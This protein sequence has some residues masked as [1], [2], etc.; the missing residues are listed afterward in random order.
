MNANDVENDHFLEEALKS[1]KKHAW[2]MKRA[3]DLDN[4]KDV[5]QHA[6]DMLYELRTSRLTPR[7]YYRLYM[8]IA[9]ELMVLEHFF[10]DM[11][12]KGTPMEDLYRMVQH[13]GNVLPRLYLLVTAGSVYI[14]SKEAP[15]KDILKDVVEMAKGVQ[16][17]MRGLF[18]RNYISH[19]TKNKLPDV[20]NEYEGDGGSVQHSVDFV[21]QNF[22]EMNKLWVRM[23]YQRTHAKSK[24]EK[25]RREL[26]VLVGTNLRRLSDLEGINVEYYK[27]GVLPRILEQVISCKDAIAQ[28]YL[29]EIII[30]VFPSEFHLATLEQFLSACKA[31]KDSVNVKGIVCNLMD[32][33]S[34]YQSSDGS[35]GL[36]EIT[37]GEEDVFSI[38]NEHVKGVIA[39]K[40]NMSTGDILSLH[41][42]LI[43]FAMQCAR[44]PED[45]V[46]YANEVM[47]FCADFLEKSVGGPVDD[48]SAELLVQL[49]EAVISALVMRVLQPETERFEDLLQFLKWPQRKTIAVRLVRGIVDAPVP[50]EISDPKLVDRLLKFIAP[51]VKDAEDAPATEL[52]HAKEE[53]EEEQRLVAQ[54]IH[55]FR[56]DN[57]DV[58]YKIYEVARKRFGHGGTSRIQYT[59]VPLTFSVMRLTR[60]IH[61]LKDSDQKP[62]TNI[63]KLFRFL[64]EVVSALG[65]HYSEMAFK[66]FLSCARL[67]DSLGF[68]PIAYEYLSQSF[69]L[70]EDM[71]TAKV[72]VRSVTLAA[73]VLY[74]CTGFGEENCQNLITSVAKYSAKLLKKPDQCRM[75]QNC[76]PLFWPLDEAH[77]KSYSDE[78]R[79]IECLRRALK[80]ADVCMASSMHVQLFVEILNSYLVLFERRCPTIHTKYLKGLV[81]LINEHLENMDSPHPQTTKF[82]ENTIAYIQVK[83][84]TDERY[85][86]INIKGK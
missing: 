67:A 41:V 47:A 32:R 72:Q 59:L 50:V 86:K 62:K 56:S 84:E 80:I 44:S 61:D 10:S 70:Y 74:E 69:T 85:K 76:C 75:V 83:Q 20:D 1:V 7:N 22:S 53:F 68:E 2:H 60:E 58:Q 82:Y 39:A 38:F 12:R 48:E 17:P 21:L 3:M 28:D 15:A 42:S 5:L 24:R 8:D 11:H 19:M 29:M 36:S 81:E 13:A 33:L 6:A 73:G 63:K 37:D 57:P 51:L 49:V 35:T 71:A 78:K 30:Q 23:Q 34:T 25:Q 66:L 26:K 31:L 18:L 27:T 79:C 77:Q 16:Q 54:L 64:H 45:Q 65:S 9:D 55:F 4:L 46:K 52:D 40:T 43:R 14:Q